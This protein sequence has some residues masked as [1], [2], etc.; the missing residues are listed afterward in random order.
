LNDFMES[1]RKHGKAVIDQMRQ[2]RPDLYL[3]AA[4]ALIPRDVRLVDER[5]QELSAAELREL[6]EAVRAQK[7]RTI[8]AK[9]AGNA[10]QSR[11][12]GRTAR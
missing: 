8:E 10:T 2:E 12:N 4:I 7:A 6:L 5:T 11:E 1:W 3:R 9:A